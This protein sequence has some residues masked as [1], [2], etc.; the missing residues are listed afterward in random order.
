MDNNPSKLAQ[1]QA[2]AA[3][4]AASLRVALDGSVPPPE[5]VIGVSG[6]RRK[7]A[8]VSPPSGNFYIGADPSVFPGTLT[9]CKLL[10]LEVSSSWEMLLNDIR[11]GNSHLGYNGVVAV[12]S[13]QFWSAVP[14]SFFSLIIGL[15][16][17][18]GGV[19]SVGDVW[20]TYT[21][22]CDPNSY[23]VGRPNITYV[24]AGQSLVF[25]PYQY[26]YADKVDSQCFLSFAVNL[27]GSVPFPYT[28]STTLL[29]GT[30]T[31]LDSVNQTFSYGINP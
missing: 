20:R 21:F 15:L 5:D 4:S 8:A 2:I 11:F 14:Q 23:A 22:P 31:M 29:N 28:I 12:A 9:A 7:A 18:P 1:Q 25:T 16:N 26:I 17:I 24:A 19:V 10:P 6:R 3:I 13:S 30:F 27:D